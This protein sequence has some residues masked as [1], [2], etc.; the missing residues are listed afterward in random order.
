MLEAKSK[1]TTQATSGLDAITGAVNRVIANPRAMR[2]LKITMWLAITTLLS[3]VGYKLR[4]K[5][6]KL[7][8]KR[9][10]KI[11]LRIG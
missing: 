3:I 8:R 1:A 4:R 6:R 9:R 10:Q 11:E 2:E 7:R 5:R